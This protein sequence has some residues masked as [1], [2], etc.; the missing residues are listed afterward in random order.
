MHVMQGCN[1]EKNLVATSAMVSRICLSVGD[2]VEVYEN[3]GAT[4]IV[5]VPLVDTARPRDTRP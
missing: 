3:I 2:R 4:M 5:P 1:H